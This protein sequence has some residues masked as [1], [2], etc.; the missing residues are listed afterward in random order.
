LYLGLWTNWTSCRTQRS[1]EAEGTQPTPVSLQ[2]PRFSLRSPR[3]IITLFVV[4]RTSFDQWNRALLFIT[5][6]ECRWFTSIQKIWSRG[7]QPCLYLRPHSPLFNDSLA[8]RLNVGTIQRKPRQV[9][10]LL[11]N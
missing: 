5:H 4:R 2:Q 9:I 10:K 11:L 6:D 1:L 8:A 3:S 7:S